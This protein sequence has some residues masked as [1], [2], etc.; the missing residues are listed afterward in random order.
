MAVDLRPL[1]HPE[2][3]VG[4]VRFFEHTWRIL[5]ARRGGATAIAALQRHNLANLLRFAKARS[6]FWARRLRRIDPER[7]DLRDI[8][9]VD[10][11]LLMEHFDEVVTDPVLNYAACHAFVNDRS[12]LGQVFAGRYVLAHT[13]GSTGHR[14]IFA[15][16]RWGWEFA[17]AA[18]MAEPV[19]ELNHRWRQYPSIFWKIPVALVVPTGGH[20]TSYLV[21]RIT[22]RQQK[23]FTRMHYID[24]LDPIERIVDQLNEL[25]P[26]V[27]HSY[28]TVLEALTYYQAKGRLHINPFFMM[29]ASEPF[30][31]SVK[32]RVRDAFP[33]AQVIDIYAATELPAMAHT[34]DHGRLHLIADWLV[35]ENVDEAGRA[36]PLGERGTKL[37]AT[38][39]YNFAQPL[40]RYEI[41]DAIRYVPEP[42]PCGSA[43]PVIEV[44]GRTN[45]TLWVADR[46]GK[47]VTLLATPILVAFM[48]VPGLRQYQLIQDAPHHIHVNYVVDHPGSEETVRA[49]IERVFQAYLSRHG[50]PDTVQLSYAAVGEIARDPSSHKVLQV[51]KRFSEPGRVKNEK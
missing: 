45:D 31:A 7:A 21:P 29:A 32:V 22:G 50:L 33:R 43:L 40:I 34:C 47:L 48:E 51:I 2:P 26:L 1:Q 20:Y 11:P 5:A 36:V 24:I 14:G 25:Q 12:K 13:S 41:T 38:C 10:K 18:S 15:F 46:T 4:M 37:Y 49:D 19:N 6:P 35:L 28:P 9:P 30:P 44:S 16:D 23:L 8:E 27:V 42:C 3:F 39:L 17:Q